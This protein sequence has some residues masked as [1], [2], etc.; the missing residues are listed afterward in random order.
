MLRAARVITTRARCPGV[1]RGHS[2]KHPLQHPAPPGLLLNASKLSILSGYLMPDV[3]YLRSCLALGAVFGGLEAALKKPVDRTNLA[4]ALAF[5]LVNSSMIVSIL[6][7]RAELEFTAAELNVFESQFLPF[8]VTPRQFRR[9]LDAAQWISVE[10]SH[11]I[12]TEGALFEEVVMVTDG[13]LE[14]HLRGTEQAI[15]KL[16]STDAGALVG[17]TS[18]LEELRAPDGEEIALLSCSVCDGPAKL[19]VWKS[20]NLRDLIQDDSEYGHTRS[21][22]LVDF[23][24][25]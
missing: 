10:E 24:M 1:L 13:R 7:E 17:A 20:A 5:L 2:T 22:S 8:G 9:I 25:L 21:C 6:L 23:G 15:A 14:L 19:L 11:V 12:C 4:W 3:L 16:A 18:F